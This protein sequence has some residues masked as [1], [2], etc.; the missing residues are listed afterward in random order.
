MKLLNRLRERVTRPVRCPRCGAYTDSY[1]S[2]GFCSR[3]RKQSPCIRCGAC[4][5]WAP[6][7]YGIL[8]ETDAYRPCQFLT[9]DKGK[10]ACKRLISGEITES[11]LAVGR[12]CYFFWRW[13]RPFD[14]QALKERVG[15]R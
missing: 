10:W 7:S 12:G 9:Q 14:F 3:C 1:R 8:T 2:S 11:Q 13:H 4:C 15:K 5:W 6:C